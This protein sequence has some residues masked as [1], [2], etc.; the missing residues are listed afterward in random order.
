MQNILKRRLKVNAAKKKKVK[1]PKKAGDT[2]QS[3]VS[4]TSITLRAYPFGIICS[5]GHIC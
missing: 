5:T 1:N 3:Y 2:I 4:C